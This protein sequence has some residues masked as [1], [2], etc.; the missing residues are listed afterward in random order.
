MTKHDNLKMLD[1]I[2][3]ELSQDLEKMTSQ[4]REEF[5]KG[6]EE[7][8]EGLKKMAKVRQSITR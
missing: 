3:K 7:I 8:Y 1:Q 2:R 5:F 6:T 4:Q